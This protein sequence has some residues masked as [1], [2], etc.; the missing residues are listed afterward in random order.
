MKG[1]RN[2]LSGEKGI[3]DLGEWHEKQ[4]R[5]GREDRIISRFG[6]SGQLRNS[7]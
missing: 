1:S 2:W 7:V 3:T 6:W 5:K 4:G